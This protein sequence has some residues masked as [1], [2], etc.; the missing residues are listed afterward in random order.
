[1]LWFSLLEA[2]SLGQAGALR[3]AER[4]LGMKSLC[5]IPDVNPQMCL[6]IMVLL[7]APV[8]AN[9]VVFH[10]QML[11]IRTM[12][13]ISRHSRN[14]FKRMVNG[15]IGKAALMS[16]FDDLPWAPKQDLRK[17]AF[18]KLYSQA[19][20]ELT[21]ILHENDATKRN[22][23]R[24][25]F[26]LASKN[27]VSLS[28]KHRDAK[29]A[30][31]RNPAPEEPRK[32][33]AKNQRLQPPKD[34]V[35]MQEA[36]QDGAMVKALS[37]GVWLQHVSLD[38]P[39]PKGAFLFLDADQAELFLQHFAGSKNPEPL[40]MVSEFTPTAEMER[41]MPST[42]LFIPVERGGHMSYVQ[43]FYWQ[44]GEQPLTLPAQ[45]PKVDITP[46]LKETVNL[47][48]SIHQR[49][50]TQDMW[51]EA[52]GVFRTSKNSFRDFAQTLLKKKTE[53]LSQDK[54]T[55]TILDVWSPRLYGK[56]AT[57]ILSVLFKAPHD[58]ER[59]VWRHSG[60]DGVF[61]EHAHLGDRD[62]L[63]EEREKYKVVHYKDE[64][65]LTTA[66]ADLQGLGDHM[67]LVCTSRGLGVRCEKQ[68][69]SAVTKV[70]L[71]PNALVGADMF[72]VKNLPLHLSRD[73]AQTVLN[74]QM[75][76]ECAILDFYVYK[77]ARHAKVRAPKAPAQTAVTMPTPSG[78]FLVEIQPVG[79][80]ALKASG[81]NEL[82]N[83]VRAPPAAASARTSTFP[84]P[85]PPGFNITQIGKGAIGTPVTIRGP[86]QRAATPQAT[87]TPHREV[88]EVRYA[89][90]ETKFQQQVQMLT[91]TV[92]NMQTS[93]EQL[94]LAQT[95]KPTQEDEE[96]TDERHQ[97]ILAR[98]DS[99]DARI[100]QVEQKADS[101]DDRFRNIQGM[102]EELVAEKR[103]KF[104]K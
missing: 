6:H 47:T 58:H 85:P 18:E 40:L 94:Q 92:Q 76:F 35:S 23:V 45:P 15:N 33:P 57:Q 7:T 50:C 14:V 82:P 29:D 25:V 104:S 51:K 59:E 24:A 72:V 37:D 81:A 9:Y 39:N 11:V 68:A 62:T 36:L 71:G 12:W 64:V 49:F 73:Q 41:Y 17:E 88:H 3:S 43:G 99:M 61:F 100:S 65:P 34:R 38:K 26:D 84:P 2:T 44:V 55:P 48:M 16:L 32:G 102:L 67:G 78:D 75:G 90:L 52:F 27:D 97:T 95:A 56:G 20:A 10:I 80:V 53:L 83:S 1:M 101:T 103:A 87:A 13:T 98:F 77:Q 8:V 74:T 28:R 70:V 21:R 69:L 30:G 54:K 46:I 79:T 42:N 86:Q 93:I 22:K 4:L 91:D 5:F 89:G 60:C 66:L 31:K 96:M 19:R 63:M